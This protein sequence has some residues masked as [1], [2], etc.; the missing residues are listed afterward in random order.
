MLSLCVSLGFVSSSSAGRRRDLSL[1]FFFFSSLTWNHHPARVVVPREDGL[2]SPFFL[3]FCYRPGVFSCGGTAT[4]PRSPYGP[5]L[6]MYIMLVGAAPVYC[7]VIHNSTIGQVYI[8][9]VMEKSHARGFSLISAPRS[10]SPCR[11]PSA[12]N[13]IQLSGSR[14]I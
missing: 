1:S 12:S 8:P 13:C 4:R 11:I 3:F 9:A 14:P 10:H 5:A 6:H 2:V 7:N